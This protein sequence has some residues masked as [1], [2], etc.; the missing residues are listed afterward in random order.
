MYKKWRIWVSIPVPPACKAGALPF[1]LIPLMVD[2]EH[3]TIL[4]NMYIHCSY[5]KL[6]CQ[7]IPNKVISTCYWESISGCFC[8]F[9]LKEL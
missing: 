8:D 1:E 7:K 2:L 5:K 9:A 3:N 6:R 4:G